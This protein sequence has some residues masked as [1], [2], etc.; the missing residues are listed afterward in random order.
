MMLLTVKN[1]GS[2]VFCL[3]HHIVAS[4]GLADKPTLVL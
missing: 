1:W 2:G 3:Q 4:C